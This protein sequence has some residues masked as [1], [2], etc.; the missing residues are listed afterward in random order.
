MY[1]VIEGKGWNELVK[2]VNKK[3]EA[4]LTLVGGVCTCDN[5]FFYQAMIYEEEGGKTITNKDTW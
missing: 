1:I 4:G 5:I 2:D 3:I